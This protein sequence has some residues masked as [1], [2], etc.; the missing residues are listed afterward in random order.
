[1]TQ[2]NIL[3]VKLFN[4][5][6]DKLKSGIKKGTKVTLKLSS[7]VVGNSNNENNFL[8]K[9]LLTNTQVSRLCK[10]IENNFS[11][12]IKLSKTQ[13]HK[14]GQSAGFLGRLLEPLLKTGLSL[15]RNIFKTLAKS[16]LILL[17]LTAAASTTDAAI[18]KKMFGSDNTTLKI[19]NEEMNIM[20]S[21][22]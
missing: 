3:N 6:L 7:N 19:S 15:M 11:A 8:H 21:L 16:V 22:M 1:M 12:N 13:L 18:H 10:A 4:S 5:Q 20:T 14:I 17:G 9:L 2:S